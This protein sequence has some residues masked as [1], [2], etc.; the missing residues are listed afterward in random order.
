MFT[1]LSYMDSL[2]S[3]I[4]TSG[5]DPF[6]NSFYLWISASSIFSTFIYLS[7]YRVSFRFSQNLKQAV[8]QFGYHFIIF[9]K[10]R[11]F[12]FFY[13]IY[14]R[15]TYCSCYNIF[16]V[17]WLQTIQHKLS[18]TSGTCLIYIEKMADTL[19]EL[20]FVSCTLIILSAY[21]ISN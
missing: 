17:K 21:I 3:C 6:S 11:C 20:N 18:G 9:L 15:S 16:L 2:F 14:S 12:I 5:P 4:Y 19:N 8:K 1:K 7:D 13:Q 10:S